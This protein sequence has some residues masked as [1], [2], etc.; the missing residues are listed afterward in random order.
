MIY[1]HF[2]TGSTSAFSISFSF[3]KITELM[4]I[5]T[6]T[7]IKVPSDDPTTRLSAPTLVIEVALWPMGSLDAM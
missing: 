4:S 3:Y 6:L 5:F 1:A 7:S 2:I